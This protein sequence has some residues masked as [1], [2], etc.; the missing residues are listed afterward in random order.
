MRAYYLEQELLYEFDGHTFTR[1]NY[2][3][4]RCLSK[5]NR[6]FIIENGSSIMMGNFLIIFIII[7]EVISEII[8]FIKRQIQFKLLGRYTCDTYKNAYCLEKREGSFFWKTRNDKFYELGF[9]SDKDSGYKC[10]EYDVLEFDDEFYVEF[11]EYLIPENG[12]IIE[13]NDGVGYVLNEIFYHQKLIYDKQ[14]DLIAFFTNDSYFRQPL[15]H[16]IKTIPKINCGKN[17]PFYYLIYKSND[18]FLVKILYSDYPGY[19]KNIKSLKGKKQYRII[20]TYE[21]DEYYSTLEFTDSEDCNN[22]F[23]E[24]CYKRTILITR[25]N[26]KYFIKYPKKNGSELIIMETILDINQISK[27]NYLGVY[28]DQSIPNRMIIDSMLNSHYL[29]RSIRYIQNGQINIICHN[30]LSKPFKYS[31]KENSKIAKY[32][33]FKN[34]KTFVKILIVMGIFDGGF[35]AIKKNGDVELVTSAVTKHKF[36]KVVKFVIKAD[37]DT[38]ILL[39]TNESIED[40]LIAIGSNIP[41]TSIYVQFEENGNLLSEGDGPKRE[42]IYHL[43]EY[44]KNEYLIFSNENIHPKFKE[45]N[46]SINFYRKLARVFIFCITNIECPYPMPL[47]FIC[48]NDNLA[49][50]VYLWKKYDNDELEKYLLDPENYYDGKSFVEITKE[51]FFE[52]YSDEMKIKVD[53]FVTEFYKYMNGNY[54]T[55][56][57]DNYFT[58]NK[59]FK[60]LIRANFEILVEN[61]TKKIVKK[62]DKMLDTLI[63]L[64]ESDQKILLKNWT[65]YPRYTGNVLNIKIV[66]KIDILFSTCSQICHMTEDFIID[67]SMWPIMWLDGFTITDR[68]NQNTFDINRYD[69]IDTDSHLSL[70]ESEN[71][72]ETEESLE[73]ESVEDSEFEEESESAEEESESESLSN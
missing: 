43:Y 57:L 35:L 33:F 3:L 73:S 16:N 13:T 23:C 8:I 19:P 71:G 67:E 50:F 12:R 18:K 25:I 17:N 15:F 2:F 72:Y 69:D 27:G 61:L 40:Y 41:T 7:E 65:G 46:K 36:L 68:Y 26:N 21:V 42:L 11:T 22:N 56:D 59:S 31:I 20:H 53:A 63:N 54:S 4:D 44:I 62:I 51:K 6:D 30:E 45:S 1:T 29:K 24:E 64:D 14:D 32:H 55:E 9:I 34:E 10:F 5:E 28:F 52:T 37:Y 47:D 60:R 49:N 38:M 70:E 66:D 39:D 58:K 48:K